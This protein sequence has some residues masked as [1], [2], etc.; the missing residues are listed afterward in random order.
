MTEMVQMMS[1]QIS[2][3]QMK[4]RPSAAVDVP[5]PAAAVAPAAKKKAKVVEPP[6]KL[7]KAEITSMLAFPGKPK[8]PCAPLNVGGDYKIYTSM[9]TGSWRVL[10]KGQKVYLIRQKVISLLFH[11][12]FTM[13]SL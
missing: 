7:T 12:Y 3:Q 6:P 4:K 5:S 1:S 11:Y 8:G 2:Q 9:A 10:K 13:I